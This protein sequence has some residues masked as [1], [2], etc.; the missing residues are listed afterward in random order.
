M[1]LSGSVNPTPRAR[2]AWL[3]LSRLHLPLLGLFLKLVLPLSLLPPLM[4]YYAGTHHGDAFIPG[5]S[6]RDWGSIAAIFL[7]AELVTVG[8]MGRYIQWIARLNGVAAD[9]T[10]AYLLA[11]IA[12]I[13]L[14]LSSL[15][16]LVPYFFFAAA[17]GLVAFAIS[18]RLIYHGA[19]VLLRVREDL[20]AGAIAYGI[21]AGGLV[22]WALLLVMI[23]SM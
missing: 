6:A 1:P 12:P 17:I 10:S 8:A 11:F 21:M 22:A 5:F 19:A 7:V 14:W 2:A 3:M 23:I 18:C 4:L 16:L 13:P 20:V 15:A 9:R